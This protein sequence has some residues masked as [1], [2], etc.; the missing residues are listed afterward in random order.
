MWQNFKCGRSWT[1]PVACSHFSLHSLCIL[2]LVL[3][4][5]W[6][7]FKVVH[8]EWSRKFKVILIIFGFHIIFNL[9]G[10]FLVASFFFFYY[11]SFLLMSGT[12]RSMSYVSCVGERWIQDCCKSAIFTLCMLWK[13]SPT[14]IQRAHNEELGP[15]L[16]EGLARSAAPGYRCC[17]E[18]VENVFET[19]LC[20]EKS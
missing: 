9:P 15:E 11:Y 20:F 5:A 4:L 7:S 16:W 13:E 3:L 14:F 12:L 6:A 1:K 18:T 2:V 8:F 17:Y 10:Y 19:W